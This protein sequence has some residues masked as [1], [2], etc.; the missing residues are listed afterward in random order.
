MTRANS[1]LLNAAKNVRNCYPEYLDFVASVD[2]EFGI[3]YEV[4]DYINDNPGCSSGAV[5][6]FIDDKL[7]FQPLKIVKD[8]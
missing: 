8:K 4:I 2:E 5:I 6:K 3:G 1:D 7:D